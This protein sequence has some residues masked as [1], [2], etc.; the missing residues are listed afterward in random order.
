MKNDSLRDAFRIGGRT[1]A[2]GTKEECELPI[3]RLV[4]GNQISIP[5]KIFHGKKPGPVIWMSAGI[6]GDEIQGV[7]IIRRVMEI[8]NPSTMA[9]TII[10]VPIVNV[11]GFLNQSRYLPDRRDLN[12]SF[13]GSPKGSL[14]SQVAHLFMKE[15]VSLCD[16]GIDMHTGSDG[17]KNLPH[18]RTDLNN[19]ELKELA[20]M[21]G[22]PVMLHARVRDGSLR[23]A[24]MERGTKVLL[25]EGGEANR[26]NEHSIIAAV[27]GITHIL[28]SLKVLEVDFMTMGQHTLECRSSSWLRAKRAGILQLKGELGDQ[29]EKGQV[30]GI[31]HDST[32]NR[33]SQVKAHRNGIIIGRLETPLI[34]QGDALY[35]IAEVSK[36]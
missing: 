35:H 32:G 21:F 12:R 29:V 13:P 8:L 14:A 11:H 16:L 25:F 10:M 18:I 3:S 31:I 27:K 2:P 6:H 9:G 15:I 24:A 30:L 26:F 1:I 22:A 4:T 5:L 23:E 20:M 17:R 33:L 7:E 34:N 28:Y 36:Q 19:P